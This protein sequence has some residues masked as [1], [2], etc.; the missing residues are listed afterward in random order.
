MQFILD[1]LSALIISSVVL[2]IA[3]G[4]QVRGSFGLIESHIADTVQNEIQSMHKIL[5]WELSMM[6]TEDYVNN[7]AIPEGRFHGPGGAFN[8]AFAQTGDNTTEFTFPT[9]DRTFGIPDSLQPPID[10]SIV[11][12][13]KY[14]L[15]EYDSA[16]VSTGTNDLRFPLYRLE[17][18]VNDTLT[19]YLNE[20]LTG[21]QVQQLPLGGGPNGF[22][23][24]SG[25]CPP[26][27]RKVR[28]QY[29]MVTQGIDF[30]D[31]NKRSTN[32]LNQGQFGMTVDLMNW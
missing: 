13:V 12:E 5:E 15:V 24:T 4:M 29:R 17:R 28:Y 14:R 3:V 26:N 7:T 21:F 32:R 19:G 11:I 20:I 30:S 9:F 1:H 22:A 27:M 31:K 23:A 18:S 6:P 25:G 8:C 10:S 2:L 16:Y